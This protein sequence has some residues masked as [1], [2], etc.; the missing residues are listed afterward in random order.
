M[1]NYTSRN[2]TEQSLA[3]TKQTPTI[4]MILVSYSAR[5]I[6][7]SVSS[8]VPPSVCPYAILLHLVSHLCKR[9][10]AYSC[11]LP[12]IPIMQCNLPILIFRVPLSYF[13]FFCSLGWLWSFFFFFFFFRF[14]LSNPFLIFHVCRIFILSPCCKKSFFWLA[15]SR[16]QVWIFLFRSVLLNIIIGV[17]NYTLRNGTEQGKYM[18]KHKHFSFIQKQPTVQDDHFYR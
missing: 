15:G 16:K 6:R 13:T 1:D 11:S 5:V 10:S 17:D 9:S 4:G 8:S 2:G 7:S 3:L 14:F 18:P 12:F